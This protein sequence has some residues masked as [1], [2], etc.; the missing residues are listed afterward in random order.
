MTPEAARAFARYNRWMNTKVYDAASRLTDEERKRDRS[1]FFRSIHGVLNH[2][3]LG[4]RVWLG[5]FL[6]RVPPAG[7]MAEGIKSL[8]QELESDFAELRRQRDVTDGELET[9]VNSLTAEALKS[10]L[11]FVRRGEKASAPMWWVVTQ[12]FN[13]QTHHRGQVTTLL[14]QAGQD[15]GVTDIFAFLNEQPRRT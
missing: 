12:V 9:F 1:A 6:G 3:L 5:R 2:I 14:F 11:H 4:D 8:D 10:E 15:P 13:H 7:F